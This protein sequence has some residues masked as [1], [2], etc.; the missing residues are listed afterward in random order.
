M[1]I[2]QDATREAA[3]HDYAA[4]LTRYAPLRTGDYDDPDGARTLF[5]RDGSS[6]ADCDNSELA[7]L[8]VHCVNSFAREQE[9]IAEIC[10]E[11]AAN[12]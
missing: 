10:K 4:T 12:V 5:A 2:Q 8:I 3:D 9:K 7:R 1:T 6:I 11:S